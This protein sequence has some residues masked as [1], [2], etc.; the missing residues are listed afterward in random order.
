M[1]L[2]GQGFILL[3]DIDPKHL[4]KRMS[5]WWLHMMEDHNQCQSPDLNPMELVWDEP[6]KA[7][8]PASA[9][10][11]W[12]ILQG[13]WNKRSEQYLIFIVERTA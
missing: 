4:R 5:E 7:K 1:R 12:E 10:Y 11:L 8:Q 9:T 3:Q 13:S 2:V 6:V